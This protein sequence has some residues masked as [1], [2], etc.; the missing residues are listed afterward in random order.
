MKYL[1]KTTSSGDTAFPWKLHM[2]LD[3]SVWGGFDDFIS[4]QSNNA[5][6]VHDPIQFE[7]SIMK[8]FF[9]QTRYKSFQRQLN[10]YG[11][12]RVKTAGKA[13]GS[14][15]HPLFIRGDPDACRF[16]TRTK[17]KKKGIRSN[18]H[19]NMKKGKPTDPAPTAIVPVVKRSLPRTTSPSNGSRSL[20][21]VPLINRSILSLELKPIHVGSHGPN[22]PCNNTMV[23]TTMMTMQ[24]ANNCISPINIPCD[25][26]S[27]NNNN[28]INFGHCSVQQNR[29]S[30]I[31]S[32]Q[33]D[34]NTTRVAPPSV[35]QSQQYQYP[36][37]TTRHMCHNSNSNVDLDLDTIFDDDTSNKKGSYYNNKGSYYNNNNNNNAYMNPRFLSP[38]E[39]DNIFDRNF[40]MVHQE[41][42]MSDH[43]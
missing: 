15:T 2:V 29:L 11:F 14:Y 21:V 32:T 5:F 40:H 35:H 25:N 16:M 38:R 42:V 41:D 19:Y 7:K 43:V 12:I 9:N 31:I 36:R 26:I 1:S 20:A 37:H 3:E 27:S 8:R 33:W 10:I 13:T 4:W 39:M 28:K 24:H 17:I 22:S 23:T 18:W 30:G 34:D 6:K